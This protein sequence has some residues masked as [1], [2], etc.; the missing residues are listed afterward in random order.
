MMIALPR[1]GKSC[2]G[3]KALVVARSGMSWWECAVKKYPGCEPVKL[4]RST[5]VADLRP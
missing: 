1:S 2:G 3:M 5:Q 4:E